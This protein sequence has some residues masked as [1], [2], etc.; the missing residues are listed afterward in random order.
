[1]LPILQDKSVIFFDLGYTLLAPASG[2]WMLTLRF[3]KEA[4]NALK[5][6]SE[7]EI[8]R[9]L[10]TGFRFLAKNHRITTTQQELR[11]FE[12]YY[13]LLSE[14]LGL[15]LSASQVEQIARDRTFNMDNYSKRQK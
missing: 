3:R 8:R 15:G 10:E 7:G 5:L 14:E 12:A 11:Q 2:D 6:R 4:G 1:M 13:V 9:A